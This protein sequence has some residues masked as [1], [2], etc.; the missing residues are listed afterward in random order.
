[1][2][3]YMYICVCIYIYIYIHTYMYYIYIY[4]YIHYKHID[5][6]PRKGRLHGW[7]LATRRAAPLAAESIYV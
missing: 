1:M 6:L 5:P 3:I 7:R 4:I 2:Y